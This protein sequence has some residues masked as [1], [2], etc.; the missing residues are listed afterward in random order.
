MC[1]K[2]VFLTAGA[3]VALSLSSLSAQASPTLNTVN[4]HYYEVINFSNVGRMD[5][6][7]A[8]TYAENSTFNGAHGYLSTLTSAAEDN[9][10]WNLGVKG[11]FL[12]GYDNSTQDVDGN[13]THNKWQWVTGEAFTYTHWLPG[14]PDN[15]QD[16]S[17]LTPDNE[18][19]LTYGGG[20]T[21]R[22]WNDSNIDSSFYI[23]D[24]FGYS[25]K[26]FVVEY[27]PVIIPPAAIPLPGA[28]ALFG[29]AVLG[30]VLHRKKNR[31]VISAE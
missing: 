3:I 19:Y 9:F 16:W 24:I 7:Q 23:N 8:K 22:G 4:D 26:G 17:D 10:V 21:K 30:F 1:K 15:W 6:N 11:Y 31:Y 13:W 12:G 20:N 14:Q 28:F 27:S 2:N 5:W 29:S 18:D 25:V